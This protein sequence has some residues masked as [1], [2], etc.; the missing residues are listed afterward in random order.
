MKLQDQ[1]FVQTECSPVL[2]LDIDTTQ[3]DCAGPTTPS[4]N[5]ED[6]FPSTAALIN[7]RTEEND[8]KYHSTTKT[9]A[10]VGCVITQRR[11]VSRVVIPEDFILLFTDPSRC[12]NEEILRPVFLRKP[13]IGRFLTTKIQ[14]LFDCKHTGLP[15]ANASSTCKL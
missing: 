2:G 4:F 7:G 11:F 3:L 13:V 5:V 14:R 6:T 10:K 9:R 15:I 1:S 8:A 12:A